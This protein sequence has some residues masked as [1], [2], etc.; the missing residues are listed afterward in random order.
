MVHVL[1]TELH[2]QS[3]AQSVGMSPTTL[4]VD[5]L[6]QTQ[7]VSEEESQTLHLSNLKWIFKTKP[8]LLK[9]CKD[10]K[11]NSLQTSLTQAWVKTSQSLKMLNHP[12]VTKTRE[13]K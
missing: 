4:S 9:R 2:Q 13:F 12:P 10:S 1:L 6:R 5:Y 3:K 11:T 7:P 8:P